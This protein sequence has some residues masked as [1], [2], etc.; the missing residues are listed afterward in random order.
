[1]ISASPELPIDRLNSMPVRTAWVA[2]CPL[3]QPLTRPD[4]NSLERIPRLPPPRCAS[5]QQLCRKA[6]R[7]TAARTQARKEEAADGK[8][9][10]AAA[11]AEA[12]EAQEWSKGA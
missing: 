6:E 10:K 8:K 12:R 11:E 5:L 9:A 3:L 4:F 7:L 1:M 2:A